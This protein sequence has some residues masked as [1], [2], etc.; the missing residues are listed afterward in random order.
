MFLDDYILYL[1]TLHNS[2]QPSIRN[3]INH[4]GKLTAA[5]YAMLILPK[6]KVYRI[7]ANLLFLDF[8]SV[9]YVP[10]SPT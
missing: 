9:L 3:S 10:S 8:I 7:N 4:F 6:V 2:D 1:N 5:P